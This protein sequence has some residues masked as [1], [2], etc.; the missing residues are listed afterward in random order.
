MKYY[1]IGCD[2]GNFHSRF[3]N[4]Q[5]QVSFQSVVSYGVEHLTEDL[6]ESKM[7]DFYGDIRVGDISIPHVRHKDDNW[8][9]SPEILYLFQMGLSE[10]IPPDEDLQEV[11]A[12]CAIPFNLFRYAP[13]KLTKHLSGNHS[14]A[15]H[16]AVCE[17]N[18]R[19]R[20]IEKPQGLTTLYR[21]YLN[22]EGKPVS[23]LAL[24]QVAVID[25]GSRDVNIVAV[26]E[27]QVLPHMSETLHEGVW[28]LVEN[29]R[30]TLAK[31]FKRPSLTE[32]EVET[33]LRSG[34]FWA[35]NDYI[36]IDEFA[37]DHK[38][39][40]IRMILT[41][42]ERLWPDVN[43]FR[44]IYITGG[45]SLLVGKELEFEFAQAELCSEPVFSNTIGAAKYARREGV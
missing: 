44:R 27:F 31:A 36:S 29:T 22:N 7:Y 19:V 11:L 9:E 28:N 5:K 20:V 43:Q 34:L 37:E 39:N 38:T 15:R 6:R 26:K 14:F 25:I 4:L 41:A 2:L 33:S 3:S 23:P 8:L 30:K 10:L 18:L 42:C 45:G 16:G 12:V 24:E 13:G 21:E 32:Y 17:H 1:H 40:F 35:G